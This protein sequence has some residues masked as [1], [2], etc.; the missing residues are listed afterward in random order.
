MKATAA[1]VSIFIALTVLSWLGLQIKPRPFPSFPAKS[2][3]NKAVPL[4]KGLPI[5]VERFYRAVYGENVPLIESAVISG[6]GRLR[7]KG[8]TFPARFRFAHR[9]GQDYRHYIVPF[10]QLEVYKSMTLI[11]VI[12]WNSFLVNLHE[13]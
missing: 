7:I 10:G 12:N 4:P 9:T 3:D 13:N 6:R 8:I 11:N 1:V 2:L 5:P